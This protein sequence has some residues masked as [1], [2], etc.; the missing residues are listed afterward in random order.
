MDGV[1]PLKHVVVIAATNRP[2]V[3]DIGLTRP[4]RFDHLI[5]VYPP[6]LNCRR[7]IFK[8]N[9]FGNKMPVSKDIQIEEM[10]IKTEG[11]SGAEICLIC[12]EAGLNAL[13]ISFIYLFFIFILDRDI[14]S[15]EIIYEDFKYSLNKVKPRLNK[16]MIRYYE[17]FETKMKLI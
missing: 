10:A 14:Q 6:D 17:E 16:E 4:G 15:N 2:D 12:R 7:E 11:Y 3:I 5:Y 8:L 9:I 1:E 13:S